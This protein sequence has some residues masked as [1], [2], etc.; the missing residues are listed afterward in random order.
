MVAVC[1]RGFSAELQELIESLTYQIGAFPNGSTKL[2]IVLN[3]AL[4]PNWSD[5]SK[6][7]SPDNSLIDAVWEPRV[8]IPFARN[9]ALAESSEAGAKWLAFI[10]DDCLPQGDW[11][12]PLHEMGESRRATAVAGGWEFVAKG[13][14][15]RW[16]P[17]GA[18]GKKTYTLQGQAYQAGDSLPTAYTRSVLIDISADGLIQKEKIS[19]DESLTHVGGSDV[20][21]FKQLVSKG[22]K[23][24]FCP[25]S[26][27]LEFYSGKR[28]TLRWHMLRRIRNVQN[29]LERKEVTF[30]EL[31]WSA[32]RELRSSGLKQ[33]LDFD[34]ERSKRPLSESVGAI[35][36]FLAPIVGALT[37]RLLRYKEYS[38]R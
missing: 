10:D 26:H 18:F 34:N 1:S 6:S 24:L 25:D 23:I 22:G 28:L 11:L 3:S 17:L 31:A 2:L 8:G 9:R 38:R 5:L 27:V 20:R 4:E 19:F 13:Q 32:M 15:S 33:S 29:L 12:K 16:L 35:L 36:L 14:K 37:V 7:W 30:R 21:F